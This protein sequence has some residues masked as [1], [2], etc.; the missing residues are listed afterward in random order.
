VLM[1]P[2]GGNYVIDAEK[3]SKVISSLEPGIVIP[4]HYNTKDSTHPEKL[5][6]LE[7]FLEEMGVEKGI[8]KRDSLELKSSVSDEETKVVV[9]KAEH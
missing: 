2:V 7:E 4:M 3:A 9:L 1:I 5:A 8:A 6:E